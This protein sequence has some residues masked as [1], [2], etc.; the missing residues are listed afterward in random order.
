MP[1]IVSV[2]GLA[3][4]PSCFVGEWDWRAFFRCPLRTLNCAAATLAVVHLISMEIIALVPAMSAPEF[5]GHLLQGLNGIANRKLD[6]RG[7]TILYK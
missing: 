1:G 5:W 4:V 6:T 3:A 2:A 7:W